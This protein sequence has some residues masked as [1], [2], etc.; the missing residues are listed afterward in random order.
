MPNGIY[1]D[2]LADIFPSV[3]S[4]RCTVEFDAPSGATISVLGIPSP[5][6]LEAATR[7]VVPDNWKSGVE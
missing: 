6:S 5:P 4:I 1:S 7:L 3:G 2:T